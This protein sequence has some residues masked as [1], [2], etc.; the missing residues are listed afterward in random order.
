MGL[1][2]K[3]YVA[4]VQMPCCSILSF[5]NPCS[6]CF[7]I[8][9]PPQILIVLAFRRDDETAVRQQLDALR[10]VEVGLFTIAFGVNVFI[11]VTIV[12]AR[13]DV[14]VSIHIIIVRLLID[15]VAAE[16]G[17]P[18]GIGTPAN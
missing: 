5:L 7:L 14:D 16:V 4:R 3:K 18:L 10:H 13:R 6:F 17:R 11:H 9:Y 15:I 8:G 1:G 12:P 2:V